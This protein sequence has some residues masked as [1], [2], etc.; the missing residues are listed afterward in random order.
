MKVTLL[1]TGTSGGVPSLGCNCKVCRSTDPRDRHLRS[2]ALLETSSTRVLIDCGPDIRE[3]LLP[4][5]FGRIDAVLLTHCHYDHI[6]GLDDL[7]PF[8]VFGAINIYADN[9]TSECV[10]RIMPYC[11]GDNLYP[12]VP[13][14]NLHVIKPGD[15]FRIGD[16]SVQ[17]IKVMHGEMPILGY[18]F[19]DLRISQT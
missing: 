14:I 17:P 7:R 18:R 6:A 16:I 12:G 11:F 10:K 9:A 1:G 8:C 3:Q 13:L 19:S 4:F 15:T 5:S 2:A